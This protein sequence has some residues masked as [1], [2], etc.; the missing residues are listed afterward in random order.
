MKGL[1]YKLL[2]CKYMDW[3][4]HSRWIK[5]EIDFPMAIN[6]RKTKVLPYTRMMVIPFIHEQSVFAW[7]V[8]SGDDG[9]YF[10]SP[11]S[12]TP[13]LPCWVSVWL[14]C[15]KSEREIHYDWRWCNDELCPEYEHFP[16]TIF[17]YGYFFGQA[18]FNRFHGI[19][20]GVVRAIFLM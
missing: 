11:C 17:C 20:R 4:M 16:I 14:C 1:F 12:I 15:K 19:G 13:F 7:K 2:L 3:T 5:K 8:M 6:T 9:G 18:S 10:F